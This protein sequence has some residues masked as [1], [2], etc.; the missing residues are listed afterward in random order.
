MSLIAGFDSSSPLAGEVLSVIKRSC[1]SVD[2]LC[3][4]MDSP[5]ACIELSIIPSIKDFRR[6]RCR[7]KSGFTFNEVVHGGGRRSPGRTGSWVR[8]TGSPAGGSRSLISQPRSGP[9]ATTRI[10]PSHQ[11]YRPTHPAGDR[12]DTPQRQPPGRHAATLEL[13][14]RFPLRPLLLKQ[15]SANAIF[16]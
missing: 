4:G 14:R 16:Q 11:R 7:D 13:S 6:S 2:I 1:K 3:R 10:P 8:L 5:R 15:S 9:P 12:A